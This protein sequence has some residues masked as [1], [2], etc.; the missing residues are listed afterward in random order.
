[1]KYTVSIFLALL[2]IVFAIASCQPSVNLP[3]PPSRFVGPIGKA[4]VYPGWASP[5]DSKFTIDQQN[6]YLQKGNS[7]IA[8]LITKDDFIWNKFYTLSN[9]DQWIEHNASC[10]VFPGSNWC[11]N[12]ATADFTVD[13]DTY[14]EG[15]NYAVAYTCTIMP[16]NQFDC[17]SG[18]WKLI[19]FNLTS[20][21]P[22]S[23]QCTDTDNGKDYYTKGTA[24][25]I[26]EFV[27]FPN[28]TQQ[29]WTRRDYC[30][31]SENLTE[32]FCKSVT[33]MDYEVHPCALGCA[34]GA[35]YPESC[36]DTDGGIDN[37]TAGTV[38][39]GNVTF[40]DQCKGNM[41]LQEGFCNASATTNKAQVKEMICWHGCANSVCLDQAQAPKPDLIVDQILAKS[42]GRLE[43]VVKNIGAGVVPLD[44]PIS[45]NV[46]D[47][48]GNSEIT[49][50]FYPPPYTPQM[51]YIVQD[52]L[53]KGLHIST[54]TIYI[55]YNQ[56]VTAVVDW[57]STIAESDETNNMKN[58][59]AVIGS[60][61]G[62]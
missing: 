47:S 24:Y 19:W 42:N 60:T 20:G 53:Q 30:R 9:Q 52:T 48:A 56:N 51:A 62:T 21:T 61:P 37:M 28:T 40:K 12:Y 8:E 25:G 18:R 27:S 55:A 4:G 6:I 2:V 49:G 46:T 5:G 15:Q 33:H 22:P 10:T 38:T 41:V 44:V 50:Q 11:T 26:A 39:H 35:C 16:N 45:V 59:L 13:Y 31:D 1:M 3:P 57:N 14:F 36:T 58:Q 23:Q 29:Y 54:S 17:S 43:I 34:D 32:Y 7:T